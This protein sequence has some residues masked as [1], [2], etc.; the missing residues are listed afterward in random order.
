MDGKLQFVMRNGSL[1]HVEIPGSPAPLPV[2][3]FTG[4]IHLTKGVWE[5]SAGRLESRDG[6]Y[7]VS[8]T[9]SPGRGFD[10]ALTRGDEQSWT[11]T[12]TLA[13]PHIVPGSRNVAKRTE[14][15]ANTKPVKP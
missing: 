13:K 2:H 5:L 14:A 8:G 7:Q 1:L 6:I 10:F 4:D 12:G 11:L 15:D 3:H 9:A